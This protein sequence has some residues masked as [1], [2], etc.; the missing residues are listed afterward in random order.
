MVESKRSITANAQG[1]MLSE[2]AAGSMMPKKLS[3]CL[4]DFSMVAEEPVSAVSL[5]AAAVI[6][7]NLPEK[8]SMIFVSP[9]I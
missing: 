8:Y 6:C 4:S 1:L 7:A 2:T 3:L 9:L 5:H